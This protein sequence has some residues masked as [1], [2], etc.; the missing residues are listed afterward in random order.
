MFQAR[1]TEASDSFI[2]KYVLLSSSLVVG[3][4][5][6]KICYSKVH[7]SHGYTYGLIRLAL[8]VMFQA[9][10]MEA[11]D[12]SIAK[13]VLLYYR[14]VVGKIFCKASYSKV[15]KSYIRNPIFVTSVEQ[16]PR[17]GLQKPVIHLG[18]NLSCSNLVLL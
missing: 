15:H 13:S 6:C 5:F 17:Q 7:G 1:F 16:T 9:R 10:F 14:P 3:K 2:A 18:P 12:S 11:S 4:I 8:I